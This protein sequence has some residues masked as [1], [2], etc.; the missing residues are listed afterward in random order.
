MVAS[1]Q[2]CRCKGDFVLVW[3]LCH[4]TLRPTAHSSDRDHGF[5]SIVITIEANAQADGANE[6][7]EI[8]DDTLIEAIE[9]AIAFA[10]RFGDLR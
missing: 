1:R 5:Q 4:A 2:H 7:I 3:R 10:D 9:L 8:I 6:G